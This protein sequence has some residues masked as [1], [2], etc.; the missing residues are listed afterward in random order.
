MHYVFFSVE[1]LFLWGKAQ[2]PNCVWWITTPMHTIID[3]ILFCCS[4]ALFNETLVNLFCTLKKKKES[5]GMLKHLKQFSLPIWCSN[6]EL[7]ESLLFLCFC[8]SPLLAGGLELAA[9]DQSG[10][11]HLECSEFRWTVVPGS[12]PTPTD[13]PP[14]AW[15][16]PCGPWSQADLAALLGSSP[17]KFYDHWSWIFR[18]SAFSSARW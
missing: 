9:Q 18:A 2:M 7:N 14:Q 11:M 13:L 8:V 3:V 15:K 16:G 10:G 6:K 12:P 5:S 17:C 1:L 4:F